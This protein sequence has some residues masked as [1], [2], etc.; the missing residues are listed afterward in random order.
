MSYT[1]SSFTLPNNNS[2]THITFMADTSSRSLS[3]EGILDT[4][5]TSLSYNEWVFIVTDNNDTTF[6]RSFIMHLNTLYFP[7]D[8][9]IMLY[10]SATTAISNADLSN[11]TF[12][13]ITSVTEE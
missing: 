9:D 11:I 8:T 4:D 5:E 3:F 1:N 6:K 2:A 13:V 12:N 7:N 10:V